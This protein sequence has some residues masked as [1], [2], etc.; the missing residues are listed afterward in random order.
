L[1]LEIKPAKGGMS[2]LYLRVPKD[3]MLMHG[4]THDTRF[5]FE[6]VDGQDGVKLVY[7]LQAAVEKRK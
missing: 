6:L 5:T 4:I 2:T 3:V 1:P 7:R